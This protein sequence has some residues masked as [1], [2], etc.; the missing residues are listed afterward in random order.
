MSA[1][2][3]SIDQHIPGLGPPRMGCDPVEIKNL[4][5]WILSLEGGTKNK[6]RGRELK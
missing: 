5:Q 4:V 1:T 6:P 3:Q 2:S